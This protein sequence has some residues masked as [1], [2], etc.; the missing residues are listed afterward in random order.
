VIASPSQRAAG[1][2]RSEPACGGRGARGRPGEEELRG[3][4]DAGWKTS[5][6]V[7]GGRRCS[8]APRMRAGGALKHYTGPMALTVP[9]GES[10]LGP[11]PPPGHPGQ[12]PRLNGGRQGR[13]PGASASLLPPSMLWCPAHTAPS[14]FH[15]HHACA[16]GAVVPPQRAR[17]SG[18]AP[19]PFLVTPV[20]C[21]H[22]SLTM[23]PSPFAASLVCSCPLGHPCRGRCRTTSSSRV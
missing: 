2:P 14:P 20:L 7:V 5:S 16:R 22:S 4:Q 6:A 19:R 3:R 9:T 11:P 15:R 18:T 12:H 10:P 23:L 21:P 13:K 1:P 8:A 17:R